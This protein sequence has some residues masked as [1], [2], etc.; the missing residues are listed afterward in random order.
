MEIKLLG[1]HN[2]ESDACRLS[3]LA[4]DGVLAL[5]AGSLTSGLS[6]DEQLG[7]KALLLT[8]QHYD[9]CRDIP[10][11]GMNLF[12]H[13]KSLDIYGSAAVREELESGLF[14]NSFYP[15][16][17]ER[18]PEEP[19]LRFN[20]I[21]AGQEKDIAGYEVLAVAVRHGVPTTGFQVTGPDG[22]KLFYTS[23]TGQ[24]LAEAW[25]Q[26]RPD[27]LI[28]E[29]TAPNRYEDFAR[30]SGH[31]TPALL[32]EELAAFRESNGYLPQV[33]LVHMNPLEEENIRAEIAAV[34]AELGAD[35]R[36]GREG[37]LL[38]L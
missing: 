29:L 36:P 28:T 35:I 32:R 24:G 19:T 25:R 31:L 30:Q 16:F 27:L 12:L 20:I 18:P 8:H 34:A 6:F 1:A 26:V 38:R 5:D 17:L 33:V 14:R 2:I 23:D 22:K 4:V 10:A 3:A 9:H 15:N 21:E 13:E 37:M 7:L 11:L